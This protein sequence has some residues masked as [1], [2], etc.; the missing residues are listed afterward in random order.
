MNMPDIHS[1]C[2]N[3]LGFSVSK[4]VPLG[5]NFSAGPAPAFPSM[6]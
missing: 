1:L 2:I 6:R 4:T 5:R 3:V